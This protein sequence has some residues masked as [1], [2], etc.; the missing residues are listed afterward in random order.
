MGPWREDPLNHFVSAISPLGI[1][2]C[3]GGNH[4][5]AAGIVMGEGAVSIATDT[6]FHITLE[7]QQAY[8]DRW[9]YV[10]DYRVISPL[11][12]GL[13]PIPEKVDSLTAF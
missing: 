11:G 12:H 1:G 13:I 2:L 4:S 8:L 3:G 7:G 6:Y 5:I 9:R 10:G